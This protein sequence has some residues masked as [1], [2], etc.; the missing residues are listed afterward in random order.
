MSVCVCVDVCVCLCMFAFV[1]I[2]FFSRGKH[3][4]ETPAVV[5]PAVTLSYSVLGDRLQN[6]PETILLP[7]CFNLTIKL[8]V[9]FCFDII[10]FY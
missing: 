7:F 1:C 6:R 2:M 8:V 10:V 4:R 3:S 5:M 9:I